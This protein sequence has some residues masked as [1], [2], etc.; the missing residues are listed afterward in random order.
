[1]LRF[2][3]PVCHYSIQ[4]LI[5]NQ[6]QIERRIEMGFLLLNYAFQPDDMILAENN[7]KFHVHQS[8]SS[9]EDY[10]DLTLT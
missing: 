9:S 6:I 10:L 5:L 7:K 1:M 2:H 3:G 4:V 8:M